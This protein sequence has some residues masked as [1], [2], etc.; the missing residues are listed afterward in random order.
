[1]YETDAALETEGI[2]MDV[3]GGAKFKV[4][5]FGG[6]NSAKISKLTALYHKP[7]ARLIQLGTLPEEKQSEIYARI[8]VESC[9][10]DWSGVKN[11][12]GEDIPFSIETAV[13]VLAGLP[14]VHDALMASACNNDLYKEKLEM[15]NFS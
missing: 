6:K 9:V 5:R 3:G 15:G 1:M 14:E 7:Y 2:W 8:F 4:R 10:V 13:E 12:K 11:D